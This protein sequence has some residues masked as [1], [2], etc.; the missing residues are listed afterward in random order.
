MLVGPTSRPRRRPPPRTRPSRPP[1]PRLSS[2][3]A[4]D[5]PDRG[6][7]E[8]DAQDARGAAPSFAP[9]R[10]A[11]PT[12][13]G[14][15]PADPSPS[16]L[17]GTCA[18]DALPA[19]ELAPQAARHRAGHRDGLRPRLAPGRRRTRPGS[20]PTSRRLRRGG[21]R[22]T[23][24]PPCADELGDR[25]WRALLEQAQGRR[26]RRR[27]RSARS[28]ARPDLEVAGETRPAKRVEARD[29]PR[30]ARPGASRAAAHGERS[31]TRCKLAGPLVP[32]TAPAVADGAEGR[33]AQRRSP[34]GAGSEDAAGREGR[35]FPDH[36]SRSSTTRGERFALN[37]SEEAG[38]RGASPSG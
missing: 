18:F 37:V 15:R 17:P 24:G 26:R 35:V 27:V 21:G 1:R 2:S 33:R 16:R 9:P 10:P 4:A 6:R 23:R 36:G 13:P 30:R 25:P 38:A 34:R 28:S 22:T 32:R 19:E 31:T 8:Q 5:P 12:V 11:H 7:G 3:R 20:S 14:K 29:D